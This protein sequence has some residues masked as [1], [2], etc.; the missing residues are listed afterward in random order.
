MNEGNRTLFAGRLCDRMADSSDRT[1]H[2]IQNAFDI[3]T[4]PA[5]Y[6]YAEN[7]RG[8]VMGPVRVDLPNTLC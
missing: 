7:N 5:R 2:Y 1:E 3:T 4:L 6:R 8:G